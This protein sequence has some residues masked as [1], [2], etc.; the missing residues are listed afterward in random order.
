MHSAGTG[1][2]R[3]TDTSLSGLA[4]CLFPRFSRPAEEPGLAAAR[5]RIASVRVPVEQADK[6]LE[7]STTNPDGLAAVLRTAWALLLRCYTGQDD[8]NFGFQRGG[9][10]AGVIITRFILDD[11]SSLEGTVGPTKVGLSGY[12]VPAP[13]GQVDPICHTAVVLWDFTKTSAPCNVLAPVTL[14]T[15]PE[16]PF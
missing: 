1:K 8:V 12:L 9:D 3:T 15:F 7:L 11:S 4:P 5:R 13:H 6:L 16:P 14:P 2:D 10:D